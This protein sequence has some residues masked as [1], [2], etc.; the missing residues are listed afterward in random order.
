MPRT[1]LLFG[2]ALGLAF[3][4]ACEASSSGGSG[5]GGSS[6]AG[7]GQG[8]DGGGGNG[9]AGDGI[10]GED[11]GIGGQGQG[12]AQQ[13]SCDQVPGVDDDM[14]GFVDGEDCNECDANV[15]PGAVEVIAQP[16]MDGTMPEP[17]DEDCDGQ[18]DNVLAS[19]DAGLEVGN[20][21]PYAGAKAIDLCQTATAADKKW[22]VLE[23]LY[24]RAD[25]SAAA[26]PDPRQWGIK[27]SFGSNVNVQGG[28][29]MF[30]LSAGYARDTAD[31]DACN[32]ITCTI[33][34]GGSAPPGFPQDVPNC[35]GS[36]AIHDDVALQLKVRTPKNA[37]GYSFNFKFYS[38]EFPEFV[39][40]SYNDQFIALVNPPPM[41]SINGNISFDSN[42]NP[43][44]VNI[45]FF[46]VCDP[47]SAGSWAQS[48]FGNCPPLPSPY[49]PSG[50]AE[51]VGTGFLEWDSFASYAG[52]TSWLKTQAPVTGGEEIQLRFAIWDTGDQAL[53][54]TALIDNFQWIANGG[55]VNVETEE[56]PEPR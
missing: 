28:E 39:C 10:G 54:S 44:S 5:G 53:D 48:C 33:N 55:T 51:L 29:R 50:T 27:P 9:T 6:T 49:C 25:G 12:G 40:T 22:G 23:A 14:D 38:W 35:T 7:A 21:D 16:N 56:V 19:C 41:G 30:V 42:T 18:I 3:I 45:A 46:D 24:V 4:T 34:Y 37:T 43:V 1:T 8:A 11:I 32:A 15:N 36:T 13:G 20:P 52:G 31:G 2:I 17:A 26:P 47:A